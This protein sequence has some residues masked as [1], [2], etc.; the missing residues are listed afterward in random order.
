MESDQFGKDCDG[1][2]YADDMWGVV[3]TVISSYNL[4]LVGSATRP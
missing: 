3:P 1:I 2:L 4:R